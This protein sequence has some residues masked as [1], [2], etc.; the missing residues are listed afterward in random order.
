MYSV[1]EDARKGS[2]SRKYTW[3]EEKTGHREDKSREE[4]E[5]AGSAD[6]ALAGWRIREEREQIGS[7]LSVACI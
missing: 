1:D 3:R 7:T 2:I 5:D 6:A 4:H